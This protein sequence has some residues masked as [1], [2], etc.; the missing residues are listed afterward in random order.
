ME[1]FPELKEDLKIVIFCGG[2][3]T[4]MWPMS[5]QA[6]PKQFQPLVGDES[7]FQLAVR[8]VR[9]EFSLSNIFF[10]IPSAQAHFIPQQIKGVAKQNIIA[11]PERRDTLGAVALVTAFIDKYFPNSLMGVVWGA[12]HIVKEEEQFARLLKIAARVC[13]AKEVICKIDVK[14]TYPSTAN[15]WVKIGKVVG[16]VDHYLIYDFIKHVEKP[17]LKEAQAMFADKNYLINT[18][19]YVWRT[20]TMLELLSKYAPDCYRHIKIIQQTLGTAK[21]KEIL[22]KEYSQI[23]KTSIDY[24][25][26]EKLPQGTQMVIPADIGWYDA[27]TWDLLYEA[28]AIG[29]R[30]NI[31]KGEVEFLE[32]KGNLVYIPKDKVSAVIGVDNL[33]IVDTKDGL[34]VCRRG[35]GG[36]VKEFVEL[37]KAKGKTSYL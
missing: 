21:E 27:G 2:Y 28:L 7:F 17:D 6:R 19:Y 31:T 16:K 3:G 35:Q 5:R 30:Q 1:E 10:S 12:D 36:K 22:A 18:G 29:Q 25:L 11:E 33:V 32:A 13:Q 26:F 4:R 9:K 20:S 24:G 8:R 15:G 34:L 23:D 37:L 14:P